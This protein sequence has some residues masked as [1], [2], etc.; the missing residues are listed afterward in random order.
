MEL[1][2]NY[3][4]TQSLT[5]WVI[6]WSWKSLAQKRVNSF[7][8]AT[9]GLQRASPCSWNHEA[10][11]D[12]SAVCSGIGKRNLF[13]WI[14]YKYLLHFL[15]GFESIQFHMDNIKVFSVDWLLCFLIYFTD[16]SQTNRWYRWAKQYVLGG[17]VT[18]GQNYNF[19]SKKCFRG[20]LNL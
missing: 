17:D 1:I 15:A 16:S 8:W 5:T 7:T 20:M 6:K 18:E 11:V 19:T 3:V 10:Q 2:M 14:Q 9:A 4:T 13:M 12:H